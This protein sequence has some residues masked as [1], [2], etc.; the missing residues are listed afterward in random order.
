MMDTLRC[1]LAMMVMMFY[2]NEINSHRV[3][4]KS[5]TPQEKVEYILLSFNVSRAIGVADAL[6]LVR[7]C[8]RCVCLRFKRRLW[9]VRTKKNN[10]RLDSVGACGQRFFLCR[11][12]SLRNFDGLLI[13][14]QRHWRHDA[15]EI[16]SRS[17]VVT[18]SASDPSRFVFLVFFFFFLVA[19]CRFERGR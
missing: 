14:N 16:S 17:V 5:L 4:A 11:V 2:Q 18:A 8:I 12:E 10:C 3:C 7:V 19:R 15:C 9:R 1:P 6:V 13:D